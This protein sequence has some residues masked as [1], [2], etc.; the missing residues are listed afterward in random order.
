[1]YF[2]E[3]LMSKNDGTKNCVNCSC[4]D[5][6]FDYCVELCFNYCTVMLKTLTGICAAHLHST[7]PLMIKT[8]ANLA[9]SGMCSVVV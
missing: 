2:A 3:V 8:F 1:M 7:C 9:G 5:A 6:D 4:T